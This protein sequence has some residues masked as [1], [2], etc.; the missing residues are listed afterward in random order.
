[1]STSAVTVVGMTCGH[2]ASSVREE[3]SAIAGVTDVDV[4]LKSGRVTIDSGTPVDPD[5][6]KRAVEKAGYELKA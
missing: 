5:V 2:C 6:I 4:D 1:V 3:V